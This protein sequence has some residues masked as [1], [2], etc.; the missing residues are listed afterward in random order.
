[1]T[2]VASARAAGGVRH[3]LRAEERGQLGVP[4]VDGVMGGEQ[5]ELRREPD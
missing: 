3:E 1:M 2:R 4:D 5:L